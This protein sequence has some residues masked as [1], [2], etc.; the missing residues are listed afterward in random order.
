M[1]STAYAGTVHL[2]RGSRVASWIPGNPKAFSLGPLIRRGSLMRRGTIAIVI[3]VVILAIVPLYAMATYD[4]TAR[5]D[6]IGLSIILSTNGCSVHSTYPDGSEELYCHASTVNP[7]TQSSIDFSPPSSAYGTLHVDLV[8]NYWQD[9]ES[10]LNPVANVVYQDG[11]IAYSPELWRTSDPLPNRTLHNDFTQNSYG[12]A[13]VRVQIQELYPDYS[14]YLGFQVNASWTPDALQP[15]S[16]P[17]VTSTSTITPTPGPGTPSVTETASPSTTTTPT[18]TTSATASASEYDCGLPPYSDGTFPLLNCDLEPGAYPVLQSNYWSFYA[19]QWDNGTVGKWDGAENRPPGDYDGFYNQSWEHARIYQDGS[20]GEDTRGT[21]GVDVPMAGEL[22]VTIS[23]YSYTGNPCCAPGIAVQSSAYSSGP[24]GSTGETYG[25]QTIS[26][27]TFTLGHVPAGTAY[28]QVAST[29]HGGGG[30]AGNLQF[31]IAQIWVVTDVPWTPSPEATFSPNPTSTPTGPTATATATS[32]GTPLLT[33]TPAPS[34]TA[35]STLTNAVGMT[36]GW[37]AAI[38]TGIQAPVT[39]N[40]VRNIDLWATS[41]GT[42]ATFNPLASTRVISGSTNYNSNGGY[43]VQNYPDEASGRQATID[44]LNEAYYTNNIALALRNDYNDTDFWYELTSSPWGTQGGLPSSVSSSV[45]TGGMRCQPS[46]TPTFPPLPYT[47]ATP[48][49]S[50]TACPDND[51][52]ISLTALP[53]PT[54]ILVDTSPLSAL[55]SLS[56]ARPACAP[57]GHMPV[58]VPVSSTSAYSYTTALTSTSGISPTY[59]ALPVTSSGADVTLID[60]CHQLLY[61]STKPE[62]QQTIHWLWDALYYL[63]VVF[64]GFVFIPYEIRWVW[65]LFTHDGTGAG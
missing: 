39:A 11:H 15:S 44:T 41:E 42:S 37:E 47:N 3:A 43:P 65:R 18:P 1:A 54:Q 14:S 28:I 21:Q 36:T 6:T 50:P 2:L 31:K 56:L 9:G 8:L 4:R 64:I 25:S 52:L 29:A 38:L 10:S 13:G 35:C 48:Y 34:P 40:N 57:I 61:D 19:V 49:P 63:Q 59:W 22:Y 53:N 23:D 24:Y 55:L 30:Y 46:A 45:D 17:T 32:T 58:F 5:A 60:P 12:V 26:D 62:S 27:G 16:T 51:C 33:Y 20:Q 7:S